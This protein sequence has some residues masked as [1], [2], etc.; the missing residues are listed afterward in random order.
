MVYDDELY[1][2]KSKKICIVMLY[3]VF[4]NIVKNEAFAPLEHMLHF[5]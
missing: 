5:P 4:E 2:L 3:K 1:M